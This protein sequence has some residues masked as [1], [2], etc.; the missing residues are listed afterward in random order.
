MRR[1]AENEPTQGARNTGST[2]RPARP[3][4]HANSASKIS[5][6]K[7]RK[8]QLSVGADLAPLDSQCV[9]HK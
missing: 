2:Q 8:R 7:S 4:R 3:L 6:E 9:K 5:I 1:K